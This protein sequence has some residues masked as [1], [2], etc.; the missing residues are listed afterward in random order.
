MDPL[1]SNSPASIGQADIPVENRID[2]LP[3]P[4]T[5][6]RDLRLGAPIPNE[7]NAWN[8]W[9]A[10]TTEK[11]TGTLLA[12]EVKTKAV[13]DWQQYR[14]TSKLYTREVFPTQRQ[15]YFKQR[16]D[17]ED[18]LL[19]GLDV[20][21][22]KLDA[23]QKT[24]LQAR[25]KAFPATAQAQ[26]I[27]RTANFAL[28]QQAYGKP[29]KPES[30]PTMRDAF[31]KQHL[32]LTTDTSD[33]A[34]YNA[35]KA[36]H[37]QKKDADANISNDLQFLIPAA[38]SGQPID[39]AAHDEQYN[40][41]FPPAVA[42]A[43][44]TELRYR[45]RQARILGKSV[46]PVALAFLDFIAAHSYRPDAQPT[47]PDDQK[48]RGRT[49]MTMGD[50]ADRFDALTPEQKEAVNYYLSSRMKAAGADPDGLTQRTVKS[51]AMGVDNMSNNAY[52]ALSRAGLDLTLAKPEERRRLED[53][54]QN[55]G[56]L[57][58]KINSLH[59]KLK[60]TD[61]WAAYSALSVA[62]TLPYMVATQAGPVGL[63]FT[64]TSLAGQ[65]YV[66][67][68]HRNP[69]GDDANQFTAAMVSGAAQTAVE[70]FTADLSL[71]A[72]GAVPGFRST[73]GAKFG[74][75][76]FMRL[77]KISNKYAR[78]AAGGALGAATVGGVEYAEEMVQE[79]V[80]RAMQDLAS[81]PTGITDDAGNPTT[82]GQNLKNVL[83]SYDPRSEKG[84]QL[85]LT[86]LPFALIGAGGGSFSS[87]RNGAAMQKGVL[88][89]R[90][91]GVPEATI[92]EI[93]TT[94]DVTKAESLLKEVFTT[95][96]EVHNQTK[97]KQRADALLEYTDTLQN[98]WQA[99]GIA[100]I[101]P[102]FDD[103]GDVASVDLTLPDGNLTFATVAEAQE[104][105]VQY[106]QTQHESM[107]DA[108]FEAITAKTVDFLTEDGQANSPDE[109]GTRIRNRDFEGTFDQ[110]LKRGLAS[111]EE[112]TERLKIFA[113]DEGLTLTE[114]AAM[115]AKGALKIRARNFAQQVNQS[116]WRY[117]V[118]LFQGA[119]P[120]NAAEDFAEAYWKHG[121]NSGALPAAKAIGWIR[122]IETTTGNAYLAEDFHYATDAPNMPLWE[123]L[124]KLSTE[125]LLHN[126]RSS[127][128]PSEFKK[129]VETMLTTLGTAW[130]WFKTLL[131][132]KDLQAAIDKG[133]VPRQFAEMIAD[134]VG[135]SDTSRESRVMA[136]ENQQAMADFHGAMPKL[137]DW[138]TGKLL[139]PIRAKLTDSPFVGELSRIYESLTTFR[140]TG[141]R[142]I[143]Q[144]RTR[145]YVLKAEQLFAPRDEVVSLDD[146]RGT[147]V[148][149]GFRFDTISDMLE[150]I[151]DAVLYGKESYA[152]HSGIADSSFSLS[153]DP[154]NPSN[155]SNPSDS[156]AIP[157]EDPRPL[158]EASN[159]TIFPQQSF[160]ISP[161][162]GIQHRP[163]EEGPRAFDLAENNLMPTDVYDHPEWYSAMEP[164]IIR[165]TMA[166]LRKIKGKANALLTIFRA[167]PSPE[168][169]TGDWVSLSKD[170]ARTHAD[171]Q[172]PTGYKVWQ[173]Q[174]KASDV[175]WDMND[176][177]EFGYFGPSVA[178]QNTN[179][180]FSISAHHGT[181]HKVDKFS[182]DK[183]GT[184]EGAQAY[185][186]G[187]YFA[188][189][190]PTAKWY[191]D[192]LSMFSGTLQ[193]DGKQYDGQR[194]KIDN[195]VVMLIVDAW[196][197]ISKDVKSKQTL[198]RELQNRKKG[199]FKEWKPRFK[200]AIEKAKSESIQIKQDKGNLYS[201]TL[202]VNDENLLDWDKPLSE[203]SEKVRSAMKTVF[204]YQP[205]S[206]ED[207]DYWVLEDKDGNRYGGNSYESKKEAL[208]EFEGT[209]AQ[210][211]KM[212]TGVMFDSFHKEASAALLA[213]GI[214]GIRYLDGNSRSDGQGSYNY[215]IFD[216]SLIRITEENGQRVPLAQAAEMQSFSLSRDTEFNLQSVI[217][218]RISRG[219]DER[220][221]I[222][223]AMRI[224]MQA[225]VFKIESRT[226]GDLTPMEKQLLGW[227]GGDLTP[228]QAE[229]LRIE[230]ALA[231]VKGIVS[232]LPA[233]IRSK[234]SIPLTRILDA[235][236]EVK[237][238]NAF[239]ELIANADE[240]LEEELRESYTDRITTLL[241]T[242]RPTSTESRNN[243]T[244]LTPETQRA[245]DQIDQIVEMSDGDLMRAEI[246][247]EAEMLELEDQILTARAESDTELADKLIR[248][249]IDLQQYILDL[250]TYG[251]ISQQSSSE[252]AQTYE[253]LRT[254]YIKGRSIRKSLDQ[255][256][257]QESREMREDIL[258][259]LAKPKGVSGPE[260]DR[261][262]AATRMKAVIE[263]I[264]A[265]GLEHMNFHE[266]FEVLF[267]DSYT[268][269]DWSERAVKAMRGTKRRR[270]AAEKR[271]NEFFASRLDAK[272][273]LQRTKILEELSQRNN[274]PWRMNE[275][276]RRVKE[277][278]PLEHVQKIINGTMKTHWSEDKNAITLLRQAYRD[279]KALP[280]KNRARTEFLSL[281]LPAEREDK[282][283]DHKSEL[284]LLDVLMT[285][286]Q[287][288]YRPALDQIGY[289]EEVIESIRTALDPRAKAL[290][291]F[292]RSEYADGWADMNRVYQ[293]VFNMDMPQI[294]NYAPGTFENTKLDNGKEAAGS[295][296]GSQGVTSAM[297]AGATKNRRAHASRPLTV[298]ALSKYW[299]HT[300]QTAYWMEWTE[301]VSEITR[302]MRSI[303]VRRAI[304]A[305]HGKKV[306][307]DV[308]TW[309]DALNNDGSA[310]AQN[311]I[312]M[313]RLMAKFVNA[314]SHIALAFNLSVPF[315][316]ASAALGALT[317]VPATSAI[318]TF[319][320]LLFRW[321]DYKAI[322]QTE[323]IQQRIMAGMSPES[324]A[325]MDSTR[326]T[327]SR[328]MHVLSLGQLHTQLTDAAFTTI[329]GLIAYDH[330]YR[331]AIKSRMP[332]E[333]AEQFAM[334]KMD[335]V[336]A[337]TSQP[338]D[339]QMKSLTELKA[340]HGF[341]KLLIQFK[342]DPRRA[343]GSILSALYKH[344]QGRI[345][346]TQLAQTLFTNWMIYGLLGQLGTSVF[347][348]I[349]D[350]DDDDRNDDN[351]AWEKYLMAALLGPIEGLFIFGTVI[352]TMA[353][354]IA[355]MP[356]F[357]N[358]MNPLEKY[359][360]GGLDQILKE[361]TPLTDR[362][363]DKAF[364]EAIGSTGNALG[365][366]GTL[367][368][369][370]IARL[371]AQLS[372]IADT[373]VTTP[374]ERLQKLS[375]DFDRQAKETA[376][377]EKETHE[378]IY[379]KALAATAAER[380]AI[381]APLDDKT[382]RKLRD[383]MTKHEQKATMT[384]LE[385]D[386]STMSEEK[387]KAKATYLH[388]NI[389]DPQQKEA[390]A[391]RIKQL[392]DIDL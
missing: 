211:Y 381:L 271:Y 378:D 247:T 142:G 89:M 379:R 105:L 210:I 257:S 63:L 188:A 294:R 229:R 154:S 267:P 201:V 392:F 349:A 321:N 74:S 137:S 107:L 346:N 373:A 270:L 199:A 165:E 242:A 143:G 205:V 4:P 55:S 259:S 69:E 186:W 113:M 189:D 170:Y 133:T 308:N 375:E 160:S 116:S 320:K 262:T 337:R 226:S 222:L 126:F 85:L 330:Y 27:A 82:I 240:V 343:M 311:I 17:F 233:E 385:R 44:S 372:D 110:M 329:S 119:D 185:G 374:A 207:G 81:L 261:A 8:A 53:L 300:E 169:N 58:S 287:E 244:L 213:A 279:F 338:A 335:Y 353:K 276:T 310:T 75:E 148:E 376:E 356:T 128:L 246:A 31:A 302:T 48:K 51:F 358:A 299:A 371:M 23:P 50:A 33:T 98:A 175:R 111:S 245:I 307:A 66:Q 362:L 104:A 255:Y 157:L 83:L 196:H 236:S 11:A 258:H 286:E 24:A 3:I 28:L 1:I 178:A 298:S 191:S 359:L 367:L 7:E 179:V 318:R 306:A 21:P 129:W 109:M 108:G 293:R 90:T 278:I 280:A 239:K 39:H 127:Q 38:I 370:T 269:K 203:Q 45:T 64:G 41:L 71:K 57:S 334:E 263:H 20:L 139:H 92:Q 251:K 296:L 141:K 389:T 26:E 252:L 181:P 272:T 219:P 161:D 341:G 65:S 171:A 254:L 313:E 122:D 153:R 232:A 225:I 215:V 387:R 194:H 285:Y 212:L 35:L 361:D 30:Y 292:L 37:D 6:E 193:I 192:K 336:V 354:K 391:M 84:S 282:G 264:K 206:K 36:K 208:E 163:N 342:S 312:T 176:L 204:P 167:G 266:F 380:D 151:E 332:A 173:A 217:A 130:N 25:L 243:K 159:A 249:Q 112:L 152:T 115:E 22:D 331:Q 40:K 295:L 114:A 327:P 281:V 360:G 322:F 316:Q 202:D 93:V 324:K 220:V 253:K 216:E 147:A 218:A 323:A 250:G 195:D 61:S 73:F 62:E 386:L 231:A 125:Y 100:I 230:D 13:A 56:F 290:H 54:I 70:K 42:K 43:M 118:E 305:T 47:S 99:Q 260:H 136:R 80:D 150:A 29:I 301:L 140:D 348:T 384:P 265:V 149:D 168:M 101:N 369:P 200:M 224:R 18:K 383:R 86:L 156:R 76:S 365:L 102:T 309:I 237:S 68:R 182:L 121:V 146:L 123:A 345:T 52:L 79:S 120:I 96:L 162:Y 344:K 288:M 106:A 87:F 377:K 77:A 390:Y 363:T 283:S 197:S 10:L 60:P 103:A 274:R 214:P 94:P 46:E 227:R 297:G 183:I 59:Q 166:Q 314:Q 268:V 382:R 132:G 72:L 351:W 319:A 289:T 164:K 131:R 357:T 275:V 78:F 117:T 172:D 291:D 198:I 9:N 91:L 235:D 238:F 187:L 333:A 174:V 364:L 124:S 328:L 273:A 49:I 340:G 145:A 317:L 155:P 241:D 355:D 34:V 368:I 2:V 19:S 256:K 277:K 190:K 339:T 223:E 15:T 180:S 134:S 5:T 67:A 14:D 144:S 95:E 177:A 352:S 304:E 221:K 326:L 135:L 97:A 315:K 184:G 228:A 248:K 88:E 209:G 234:V 303:E 366:P 16:A 350:D 325:L 158:L 12:P 347:K 284:E 138:I 388:S 32:G